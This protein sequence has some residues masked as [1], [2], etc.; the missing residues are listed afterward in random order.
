MLIYHLVIECYL[1]LMRLCSSI[2]LLV[3][4]MD[5]LQVR[6]TIYA[7]LIRNHVSFYIE[8]YTSVFHH[9][10]MTHVHILRGRNSTSCTFVGGRKP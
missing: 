8:E 10:Y 3:I 9:F 4:N 1:E 5:D 6:T 7:L 2:I